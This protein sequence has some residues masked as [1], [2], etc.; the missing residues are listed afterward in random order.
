MARTF[1]LRRAAPGVEMSVAAVHVASWQAGYAG[2]LAANYL[3]A[4]RVDDRA[5]RY[6]RRSLGRASGDRPSALSV[7]PGNSDCH[8]HAASPADRS[9]AAH[10]VSTIAG[11]DRLS[12]ERT[13]RAPGRSLLA[14]SAT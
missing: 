9:G 7:D 14:S 6:V 3:D 5:A 1:S 2:L 10:E 11:A 13:M 8:S 4:L 12:V